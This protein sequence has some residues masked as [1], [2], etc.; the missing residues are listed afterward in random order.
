MCPKAAAQGRALA[1]S[2]FP[3]VQTSQDLDPATPACRRPAHPGPEA[4]DLGIRALLTSIS[5]DL[6]PEEGITAQEL[7]QLMTLLPRLVVERASH[8][9]KAVL[10]RGDH[11][12][13]SSQICA[14]NRQ[15]RVKVAALLLVGALSHMPN[16]GQVRNSLKFYSL[17]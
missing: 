4:R 16:A 6:C 15:D 14:L 11:A 17:P 1:Y 7:Q 8:F 9:A 3:M 5:D 2:A 13:L 12:K 10:G